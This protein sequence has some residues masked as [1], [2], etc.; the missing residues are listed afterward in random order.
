MVFELKIGLL[1]A[2]LS[3][4][5]FDGQPKHRKLPEKH[6]PESQTSTANRRRYTKPSLRV[7]ITIIFSSIQLTLTLWFF[8]Q[9]SFHLHILYA[10]H[11]ILSIQVLLKKKLF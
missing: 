10:H 3:V 2:Y 4:A 7:K 9:S 1:S 11:I 8:R 6:F 5:V